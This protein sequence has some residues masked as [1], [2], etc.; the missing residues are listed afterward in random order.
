M[1]LV[2]H[3]IDLFLAHCSS[4][5]IRSAVGISGKLPADLHNLLLIDHA[6]VGNIEDILDKRRFIFDFFRRF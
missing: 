2:F 4:D 3:N 5:E 6:A 1:A